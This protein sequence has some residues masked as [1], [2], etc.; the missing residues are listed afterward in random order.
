MGVKIGVNCK[1]QGEVI[2]DY[3]HF[4]HVTIG[5]NVTI[6]PRVHILAHDAS[7]VLHAGYAKIGKVDIEDGVFIGAGT[8]VL[9]GVVIGENAIVGAGS[10]VVNNIPENTVAVGS[11]A[12]VVSTLSDYLVK[13]NSQMNDYPIF[14][15]EYTLRKDVSK[16]RMKEMNQKMKDRYGFVR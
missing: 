9:P 15:E 11:P 8:I 3:S 2:I 1:I 6:A 5:N 14:E 10:I 7:T 13:V 4:W 12:K 16:G